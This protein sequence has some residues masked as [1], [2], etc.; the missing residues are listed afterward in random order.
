MV[1]A[2]F[3]PGQ[4]RE[5]VH[6]GV[7][8]PQVEAVGDG[9]RVVG[10]PGAGRRGEERQPRDPGREQQVWILFWTKSF[11]TISFRTIITIIITNYYKFLYPT[12]IFIQKFLEL[13]VSYNFGVHK[14]HNYY[15]ETRKS[16]QDSIQKVLDKYGSEILD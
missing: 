10:A 12:K 16:G 8:A 1:P 3:Q 14:S 9:A 13:N 6:A 5:P 7:A 15:T 2:H 11:G 4:A